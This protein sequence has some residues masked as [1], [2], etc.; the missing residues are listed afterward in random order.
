MS[1][2][3]RTRW[4]AARY[5]LGGAANSLATWV[6]YVGL[7]RL[8]TYRAAYSVAF[9]AGVLLSFVVNSWFVFRVPLRWRRLIPYPGVYLAQYLVGYAAVS[10]LVERGGLPAPVA[11]LVALVVTVP[12]GFVLTRLVLAVRREG[13]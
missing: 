4:T 10:L 13:A 2:G 5:V 9:A 1:D 12:L 11:P 6:L 7:L 3:E 8:L